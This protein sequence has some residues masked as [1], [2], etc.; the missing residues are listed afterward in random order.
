MAGRKGLF[1]AV[2]AV[3][4]SGTTVI[5]E[6]VAFPVEKLGDAILDLQSLF[7]KYGYLNAIIFGH[8]KD[9]NIHFVV[10]QS[11]STRTEV[12]RY[13]QFLREVVTL[14]VEKYGGALK[15]EHGTGRNMAPF[16]ETEWGG[17]AYGIMKKIK[18]A[19]D[20]HLLLN[21]GVIINEN[22]EAHI[23]NL[24]DLPSVEQEVDRCIECGYCEHKCPSRDITTTP[25]RRIVVRRALKRLLTENDKKNYDLLLSQY[26]Y[27]GLDTCAVD[28]LCATA[29]PV[30]I[31]TGDLIKRLRQE[32][33]A[34]SA[35][36]MALRVAKNFRTI[37]WCTRAALKAGSIV[38]DVFGKGSMFTITSGLRKL[39]PAMPLWSNQLGYPP[40]LS[41]LKQKNKIATKVSANSVVYFPACI[42]RTMGSYAGKK[43]NLFEAFMSICSKSGI[44]VKVLDKF[45]GSCCSQI[46]SSK[47]FTE[48]CAFTAND[49]INR[50]WQSSTQGALPIVID[51]S[52]C[53]YTLIHIR[54]HLTETNKDRFS[55]L[56][57]LD[58]VDF[59]HDLVME[60]VTPKIKKDHIVLHPVC[61]LEKMQTQYKFVRLA[62]HFAHRVTVPK[63]TGCCGMAGDRGFLFP[64]LTAA[65]TNPEALEVM[66]V[67]YDG[68]YSSTKTCEIAMS[69]AVREN[70]VSILYLV[71]EAI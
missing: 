36:K 46:F 50:L 71:D 14:V 11:F 8:A 9:G 13:D 27:E 69:D 22:G 70:Y 2:G 44:D 66:Q 48:A 59:L 55:R 58:S 42:S 67:K 33:H 63:S 31:N 29:C 24:K 34:A 61:S 25:R 35:N 56:T 57:I 6:D 3:R 45:N 19:V 41:V 40:D 16:V 68:Y 30:D 32:N 5:L 1:P 7:I 47:G 4:A 64:E 39:F 43:K 23:E 10:T 37:E 17:D 38:N 28:G 62:Q 18:Q 52:S 54:P 12:S 51:V 26:Q 53:A 65:A 15:A 21:P 60:R 20:P 49:I